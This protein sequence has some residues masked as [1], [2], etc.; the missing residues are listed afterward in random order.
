MATKIT[1]LDLL[2]MSDK[3]API[4]DDKLNPMLAKV[5]YS[6]LKLLRGD[7]TIKDFWELSDHNRTAHTAIRRMV[8]QN[9]TGGADLLLSLSSSIIAA[10]QVLIECY[11][12]DGSYELTPDQRKALDDGYNATAAIFREL[13][14]YVLGQAYLEVRRVNAERA[15]K[16]KQR[17]PR[18]KRKK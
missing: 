11:A 1:H 4:S 15:R 10:E 14:Q 8:L 5:H 2:M 12:P 16:P 17:I 6:L 18:R 13:P 7:A 3:T 9:D